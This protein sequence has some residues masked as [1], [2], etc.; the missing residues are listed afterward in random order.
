M[1]ISFVYICLPF[2]VVYNFRGLLVK[3]IR[4]I[5]RV[6]FSRINLDRVRTSVR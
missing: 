1:F 6:P 3:Q 2:S 5:V 4:D